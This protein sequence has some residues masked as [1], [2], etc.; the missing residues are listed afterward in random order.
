MTKQQATELKELLTKQG[1]D[2]LKVETS[3]IH[4]YATDTPCNAPKQEEGKLIIQYQ[5]VVYFQLH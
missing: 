1:F 4:S 2:L 3:L 5:T